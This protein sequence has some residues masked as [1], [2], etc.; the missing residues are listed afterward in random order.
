MWGCTPSLNLRCKNITS[1]PCAP[2]TERRQ[3]PHHVDLQLGPGSVAAALLSL[4]CGLDSR[5]LLSVGL[6]LLLPNPMEAFSKLLYPP[7]VLD[8][9]AGGVGFANRRTSIGEGA[10]WNESL[11]AA[12]AAA[13]SVALWLPCCKAW[14]LSL[15]A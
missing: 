15:A 8:Y 10:L 6:K 2:V 3:Q 14:P 1:S 5:P 12:T 13:V 11:E 7:D 4:Q 9:R